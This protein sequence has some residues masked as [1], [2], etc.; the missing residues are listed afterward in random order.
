MVLNIE[1]YM[2]AAN[3]ETKT[4]KKPTVI[5]KSRLSLLLKNELAK[6]GF[7]YLIKNN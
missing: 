2:V 4:K 6:L 7:C 1:I 3:I 5:S